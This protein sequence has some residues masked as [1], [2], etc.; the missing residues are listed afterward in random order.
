MN[1]KVSQKHAWQAQVHV[2]LVEPYESQNIGAAARALM[3]FGCRNLRVVAPRN[4]IL[5][6]AEQTACWA[7][8]LLENMIVYDDLEDALKDMEDVIAFSARAGQDRPRQR[9]LIEW[10]GEA[11]VNL[12]KTAL[13]F[14]PENTGLRKEHLEEARLSVRIPSSVE[15][16]SFNLSQAVLLALYE[17]DRGHGQQNSVGAEERPS[18]NEYRQLDRLVV[19]VLTSCNF[20]GV[21]TPEPVPAIV[22]N[23][24]RRTEPNQREMRILLGLFNRINTEFQRSKNTSP[25]GRRE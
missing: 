23:L 2:I 9:T 10:V 12:P 11:P 25:I 21:G 1:D 5:E 18:W 4:F 16:P 17:L 13:L 19:E 20:Y 3:N 15:N 8:P 7:A 24:M 6:R 22:K 14:G